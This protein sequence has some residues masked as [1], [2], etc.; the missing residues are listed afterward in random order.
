MYPNYI[1][2]L[3]HHLHGMVLI[4][5]HLIHECIY[6]SNQYYTF[7]ELI[8]FES[9]SNKSFKPHGVLH[10]AKQI[11]LEGVHRNLKY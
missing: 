1:F 10:Y 3:G 4:P 6:F 5:C 11:N 9:P 8:A 2:E 7:S